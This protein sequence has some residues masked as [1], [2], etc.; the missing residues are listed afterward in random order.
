MKRLLAIVVVCL[1]GVASAFGMENGA[2]TDSVPQNVNI[3]A[4]GQ[5]SSITNPL[6]AFYGRRVWPVE[7]EIWLLGVNYSMRVPRGY[8]SDSGW[9]SGIELRYNIN[10]TPYAVGIMAGYHFVHM[11][12][13]AAI[14]EGYGDW[15][16]W[17]EPAGGG[18]IIG[19]VFE[20][21]FFRGN[22]AS[23][24][25]S[26]STGYCTGE[27]RRAYIRCKTGVELFNLFRLS[28]SAFYAGDHSLSMG[29]NIGLV[30]GGWPRR[31][32]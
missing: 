30:I 32:R 10:R 7:G 17:S 19:P 4:M 11:G 5:E 25:G 18:V 13:T 1:A 16:L 12:N 8:Q 2:S 27:N 3:S 9:D 31:S 26:V 28:L 22:L 21:D 23:L 6:P 20:A 24:Y 15:C 29:A 14:E